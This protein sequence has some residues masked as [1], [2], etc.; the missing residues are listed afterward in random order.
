MKQFFTLRD[1][2]SSWAAPPARNSRRQVIAIQSHRQT[3][4]WFVKEMEVENPWFVKELSFLKDHVASK[5][6]QTWPFEAALLRL[7]PPPIGDFHPPK[8]HLQGR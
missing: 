8:K 2:D 1:F 7:N 6:P 3:T 5:T 4:P